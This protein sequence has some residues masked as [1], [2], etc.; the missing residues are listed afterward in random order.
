MFNNID[1]DYLFSKQKEKKLNEIIIILGFN[2]CKCP[3][4]HNLVNHYKY[5]ALLDGCFI[6]NDNFPQYI[7][8][9]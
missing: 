1:N 3:Q 5:T 6:L 8:G 4:K 9:A 2:S 7:G